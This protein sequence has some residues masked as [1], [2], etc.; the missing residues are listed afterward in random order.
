MAELQF[1]EV[2]NSG[3]APLHP[4]SPPLAC[5]HDKAPSLPL[6][7]HYSPCLHGNVGRDDLYPPSLLKQHV[8]KETN[9]LPVPAAPPGERV[10]C[11]FPSYGTPGTCSVKEPATKPDLRDASASCSLPSDMQIAR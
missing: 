4:H 2:T 1:A 11:A 6:L 9:R 8:S 5:N 3:R 10:L 7:C